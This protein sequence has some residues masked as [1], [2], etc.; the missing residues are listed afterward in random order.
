[1]NRL[2]GRRL[3]AFRKNISANPSDV[4]DLPKKF[5]KWTDEGYMPKTKNQG[6]CGSCYAV[7]TVNMLEARLK[8]KFPKLRFKNLNLSVQHMLDCSYYNQ[9]CEGG[10][11]Y[12]SNK[13]ASEFELVD[14]T[15]HP[16]T[17]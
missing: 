3:K 10:Y 2:A 11:P 12:L 4:S 1:M 5:T 6:S 14:N 8:I 17:A 9:G 13:F 16:Y 7:A 15:C